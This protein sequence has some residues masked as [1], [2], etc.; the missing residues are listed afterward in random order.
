MKFTLSNGFFLQGEVEKE[1]E[2]SSFA[3]A[4]F[5]EMVFAKDTGKY[6]LYTNTGEWTPLDESDFDQP[7]RVYQI[8]GQY[9][10]RG[11]R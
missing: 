10:N 6:F 3:N 9:E 4:N 7:M 2:L 1:S 5:N 8:N 11:K